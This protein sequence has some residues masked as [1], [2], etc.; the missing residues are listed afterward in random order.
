MSSPIGSPTAAPILKPTPTLVSPTSSPISSPVAP[1]TDSLTYAQT[2]TPT[3]KP[4][5]VVM[6]S[7][8][9]TLAPE[10]T[11]PPTL[12]FMNV[13]IDFSM[14]ANGKKLPGGL[15]VKD[16][17]ADYGLTLSAMGGFGTLPRLFT[18]TSSVGNLLETLILE[19]RTS[20][21]MY[22]VLVWELVANPGSLGRTACPGQCTDYPREEYLHF[23][24]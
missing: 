7:K 16:E 8:S 21:A 2:A 4:P 15:Y 24:S 10:P 17:W 13:T 3:A 22:Q 11:P 1:P 12:L 19:P 23:H 20:D 18:N 14:N 5:V 6:P 9:P